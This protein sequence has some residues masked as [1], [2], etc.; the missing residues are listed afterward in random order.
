MCPTGGSFWAVLNAPDALLGETIGIALLA[1]PSADCLP[2]TSST[3]TV[4]AGIGISILR[5]FELHDWGSV[6]ELLSLHHPLRC[7]RH[8][9]LESKGPPGDYSYPYSENHE[10]PSRLFRW[11]LLSLCASKTH[12]FLTSLSSSKR[13]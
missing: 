12:V 1:L 5:P 13:K 11:N 3:G 4:A 2:S 8:H 6:Y 9:I 10:F 7:L